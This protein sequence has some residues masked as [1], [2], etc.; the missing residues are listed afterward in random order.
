MRK[1]FLA[2][3]LATSA[4]P[5]FAQTAFA[6]NGQTVSVAEQKNLMKAYELQGIKDPQKQAEAARST[7]IQQKLIEQAA[8]K[9]NI[10][11]D[12]AVKAQIQEKQTEVYTAELIKRG[13]AA[14]P[15]TEEDLL[16]AYEEIKRQYNPNEIKL[17]HILVKSEPEAKEIIQALNAGGD[18]ASLAKE[19]SLD[20]GTAS[21]GG[22]IPFTN[23][24]KIAIPGLAETAVTLNKGTLLPVPF[25]SSL[26]YHVLQ[27]QDK[28]EVPLPDFDQMKPQ[29][30]NTIAQ[31]K[32]QAIIK[33]ITKDLKI[34]QFPTQTKKKNTK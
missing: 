14:N 10:I 25:H 33:E 34:T 27:L 4:L 5:V 17:R 31:L 26:G 6:V 29:L 12:P 8:R 2:A 9:A 15:T 11:N 32:A 28:R 7:L 20:A 18:F 22:E 30:I 19:K 1:L 24:R 23:I 3:L 13:L 16:R 21:L